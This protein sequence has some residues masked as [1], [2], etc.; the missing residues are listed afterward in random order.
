MV[1][2]L[3]FWDYVSLSGTKEGKYIEYVDQ[4]HEHFIT[5]V[6]IKS[7]AYVPPTVTICFKSVIFF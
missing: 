3:Q 7:A 1:Q 2:H 6:V 5:P 4:Q